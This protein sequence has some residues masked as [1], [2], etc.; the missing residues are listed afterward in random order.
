MKKGHLALI[1]LSLVFFPC[2]ICCT[3]TGPQGGKFSQREREIILKSDSVM[4]V[5]TLHEPLDTAVLRTKCAPLDTEEISSELFRTLTAKMM[6]TVKSPRQDGV[7]LAATQVG[8]THRV[9]VVQRFD[10]EG[11]P[12]E[13]YPNAEILSHGDSTAVGREGCLSFPPMRGDVRRYTSVVVGYT[14]PR[15]LWYTRDTVEGFS[16]VIF[17][18]EVDHLEGIIYKDRVPSVRRD[19]KWAA[20]RD[21]LGALGLYG[22]P[23]WME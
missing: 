13:I 2:L 18:H 8:L 23:K 1:L 5:Y 16:A 12:F 4:Y 10:K 11:E 7:G 20:T 15:T 14:D 17:Q 3:G 21:S 19:G 6:S 9:I 22:R